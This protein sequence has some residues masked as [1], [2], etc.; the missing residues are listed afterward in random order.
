MSETVL[1]QPATQ[2]FLALPVEV[3]QALINYLATR[4]YRETFELIQALQSL[5][6]VDSEPTEED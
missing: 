2:A 4:P 1:E 6:T 3:G 5:Q